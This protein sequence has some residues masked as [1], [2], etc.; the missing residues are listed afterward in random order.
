MVFA[1]ILEQARAQSPAEVV[2]VLAAIAYLLFAIRQQIICWLFAAVSTS[3]YIILFV[4]ARLYMES[5]LNVF[6]LV[7]A[8]YGFIVWRT[9]D[10]PGASRPVVAWPRPL[11][12]RTLHCRT[13]TPS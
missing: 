12:V 10:G 3:I 2:A 7:M 4:E 11:A 5:A 9:G 8:A 13:S 1:E 6:Y